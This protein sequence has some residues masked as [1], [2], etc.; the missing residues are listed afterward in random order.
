MTYDP[1]VSVTVVSGAQPVDR[2]VLNIP[3][4]LSTS[5]TFPERVRT[6]A[7]AA[8]AAADTLLGVEGTAAVNAHFA[9]TLHSPTIKIGRGGDAATAQVVTITVGGT[10]LENEVYAVTVNGI[11]TEYVAGAAPTV[12]SV[13]TALDA[14][15][16]SALSAEPLTLSG[17]D[18]DTIITA[19]NAG[20]PFSYSVSVSAAPGQPVATGTL[21]A[22]LTTPNSGIGSDLDAC[23]AEDDAW[24]GL[25]TEIDSTPATNLITME[26]ASAWAQINK[27]FYLAQS[28]DATVLTGA[29]GNDLA[30]LAAKN[31]NRTAYIWHQTNTELA[32]VAYMSYVFWADPDEVTTNWAYKP[33]SGIS[34][35]DP[36]I[37]STEQGFVE[38]QN[39]NIVLAFGGNAVAGMGVTTT[40]GKIDILITSDW[41]EARLKETYIQL[42]SDVS[43]R[44]D[45]IGLTDKAMQIIPSTG[46]EI[47]DQGVRVGH[48]AEGTTFITIPK[49]ADMPAADVTARTVRVTAGGTATGAAE[50]IIVIFTLSLT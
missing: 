34:L 43:A 4:H 36:R 29:G 13:Y 10:P 22:V 2:A 40:G 5:P 19:D 37:T 31:N 8:E 6:Y 21:V 49:R 20:E 47:I 27:K 33:L 17:V 46:Q 15:V 39:G 41:L 42:L 50:N 12:S 24:Y 44:N 38:V 28:L 25:T 48:L 11:T 35:K 9:Q 32:A 3:L 1:N 14:A 23:L 18:P 45:K 16:T 26:A 30:V 7:S